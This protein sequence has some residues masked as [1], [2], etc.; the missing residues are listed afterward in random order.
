MDSEDYE[1]LISKAQLIVDDFKTHWYITGDDEIQRGTR[2]F[3]EA[4]NELG[5]M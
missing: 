4:G 1:K 5:Y 2:I 3:S